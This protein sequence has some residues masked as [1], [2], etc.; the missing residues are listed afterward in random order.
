MPTRDSRLA[1]LV[2]LLIALCVV[3]A[4]ASGASGST[5]GTT[6]SFSTFLGA[7]RSDEGFDVAVDDTGVYVLSFAYSDGFPVTPGAFDTT[8]E[9]G[10]AIVSKLD[11]SG[12]TLI[13]S[14]YLGGSG[15]ECQFGCALEVDGA[16]AVYVTG[17]TNSTDFP[18]TPGAFDRTFNSTESNFPDVFVAKLSPDGSSLEYGTYLGGA[19]SDAGVEITVDA[20]GSAYVTGWAASPG[21]PTTPGAFQTA[22]ADCPE[23]HDAFV[24]KLD[25]TASTLEYSTFL[26]GTSPMHGDNGE[27]IRVDA[28][29]SAYVTGTTYSA[30]FPTTPGAFDRTCDGCGTYKDGFVTKLDATGSSLV[31]STF[32]GGG[33]H[34]CG[35]DLRV[36]GS[37]AAFVT[38][39]TRSSDFPTTPGAFDRTLGG[40][41]TEDAFVAKLHPSGGALVYSTYL[42]GR[43]EDFGTGIALDERGAAT[44]TGR[45]RTEDFPT[46]PDAF[47]RTINENDS[48]RSSDAFV[49]RL[50]PSGAALEYSTYL[51]AP[52]SSCFER[53]GNDF[54]SGAATDSA[55]RVYVTGSTFSHDF[56]TTAGA[57][58][59]TFNSITDHYSDVFVAAFTPAGVEPPPPPPAALSTLTLSPESVVGGVSSEG[60]VTL[61][62]PA[63]SGDATVSL[64][65]SD[66]TVATVPPSVTVPASAASASFTVTTTEVSASTTVTISASYAGLT[67]TAELTVTPPPDSVAITRA[68]YATSKRELRVEATST[69]A[70]ATL[71]VYVTSTDAFVGALT[72][73]GGGKHRGQFSWP[74][75][76]QSV[77]V[78][79]SHGGSATR[80]VTTR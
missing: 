1:A 67:K 57:Y 60:A 74:S 3:L 54:G 46:T 71:S 23:N 42:G 12:S 44:V 16:G 77:T 41:S 10:D 34:D 47:D 20:S 43:L 33:F 35:L 32:L 17:S 31:Y 79:S 65:S 40:S 26:G 39:E 5:E 15:A 52:G 9:A 64:A 75:N 45:T 51:G 70:A 11:P 6:L 7:E 14:T 76:P 27:A 62:S 53:C 66:A 18:I 78:R 25:P 56:P 29:G 37:G 21:F 61:T 80:T 58:D 63:P 38:G 30:D 8:Y 69:E 19:W 48:L 28:A 55:G 73:S 22:C 59:T 24:A 4:G 13:W 72:K 49:T 36:D 2:T 50:E 68:E